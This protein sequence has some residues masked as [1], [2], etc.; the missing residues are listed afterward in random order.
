MTLPSSLGR[1]AFL[2]TAATAVGQ[3]SRA[4]DAEERALYNRFRKRW[5]DY[6]AVV[7]Q[8][9]E[10]SRSGRKDEAVADY[11]TDLKQL[12][13]LKQRNQFETTSVWADV[14]ALQRLG[15]PGHTLIYVRQKR[16][17]TT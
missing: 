14:Q 8:M 17:G 12:M 13:A 10:L 7:N 3:M 5:N 15:L 4:A 2:A 9:L 16:S 6:R 1:R 11:H